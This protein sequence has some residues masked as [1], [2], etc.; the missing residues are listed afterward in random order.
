MTPSGLAL[1]LDEI[2]DL[3]FA[4]G[5]CPDMTRGDYLAWRATIQVSR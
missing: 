5:T 2:V 4:V 1:T 3:R